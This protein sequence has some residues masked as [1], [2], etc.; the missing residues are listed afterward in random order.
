MQF[1]NVFVVEDVVSLGVL[2]IV[3]A[4]PQILADFNF[5]AKW[6]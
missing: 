2:A 1:N 3:D 6:R 4:G 5:S